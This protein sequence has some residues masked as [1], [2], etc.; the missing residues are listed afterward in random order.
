MIPAARRFVPDY[1]LASAALAADPQRIMDRL[2]S[3]APALLPG[4]L[5]LAAATLLAAWLCDDAYITF[6]TVDNLAEGR[7]AR[8]NPLE[9]VQSYTH[10]L[11]ML[12]LTAA[13]LVTGELYFTSL[14]LSLLLSWAAA[15]LLAAEARDRRDLAFLALLAL[16]LSRSFV[17]YGTSGLEN[18]L[19][20]LLL[21]LWA[22][23]WWSQAALPD[24]AGARRLA[25]L[26]AGVLLCRLDLALLLAPAFVALLRRRRDGAVLRALALGFTP[27]LAWEVFSLVYYGVPFPNTA[28]AKL[29]AG[30]P[31]AAYVTQ[32]F[33]YLGASAL[34][35][36]LAS[37]LILAAL[38]LGAWHRGAAAVPAALGVLLYLLYVVRIGGDFMAGRFLTAPL[39]ISVTLLLR[40]PAPR[41]R[42]VAAIAA[43]VVALGFLASDPV[44][45]CGP[46][47][48]LDRDDAVADNGVADERAFYYPT[49][50]LLRA[51]RGAHRIEHPWAV[52]GRRARARGV[53][54]ITRRPIGFYGY[55]AG[56]E[57][58]VVDLFGLADPLT[59]RLPV[60]AD[61][62]W[63]I[64]HLERELPEGYLRSVRKPATEILDPDLAAL[65]RRLRLVTRGPLFTAERW[66]AILELNSP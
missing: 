59:A 43:A 51:Q 1:A 45:L 37:A 44:P 3:L 63:R 21:V 40:A 62:E 18:P 56:P 32:G 42:A 12:L 19:S 60:R 54:V 49:T 65:D 13:R 53:R 64:G 4:L 6:R 29:G 16:T 36:P 20:H 27:L 15:G 31:L 57:C 50:G 8:W 39:V 9:R 46:R 2:R 7:G 48:G 25:L 34:F 22:R 61:K 11:W 35:D 5:L 41:P 28:Y 47:F 52:Q 58:H 17:D 10:P 24:P 66:R 30:I 33:T 23:T 14:A 38:A 55:F 26:A